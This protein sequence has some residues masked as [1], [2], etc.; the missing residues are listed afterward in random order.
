MIPASPTFLFQY[1]T[2]TWLTSF[3]KRPSTSAVFLKLKPS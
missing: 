1:H 2:A 3:P